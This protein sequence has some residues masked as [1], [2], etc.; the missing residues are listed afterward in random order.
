MQLKKI[1]CV[2]DKTESSK[3]LLKHLID[4][5]HVI[6]VDSNQNIEDFDYIVIIG[7]DGFMLHSLHRFINFNIPFYGINRGTVGF[8]LNSYDQVTDNLLKKITQAVSTAIFPLSM[9]VTTK[10]GHHKIRTAINEVSILRQST[11]SASIRILIDGKERMKELVGDG[12]MVATAAG[13]SAYN[14]SVGGPIFPI[15]SKILALTP[16]SPFRPR[17]WRGA[18]MPHKSVIKFEI[19]NC[20]KRPVNAVADFHE[21]LDAKEIIVKENASKKITLLFD[22][23]HNLEDR[24]IREQFSY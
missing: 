12:I 7:G 20:S 16:I 1:A 18:L 14:F 17:R 4:K 8:L 6:D 2:A 9:E 3:K 23:N 5:Y 21:I 11:Q 22:P 10:A 19:Q 15:E 24:I 13:S